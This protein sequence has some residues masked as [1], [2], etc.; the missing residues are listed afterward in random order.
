[1]AEDDCN[2]GQPQQHDEGHER[3]QAI[4][5]IVNTRKNPVKKAPNKSNLKNI[6]RSNQLLQALDLPTVMNVN[7]R[8]I[9]NKV[10]EFHNL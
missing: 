10:K 4:P 2:D 7:P 1:M 5:V 3:N 6:K 8:S 9:Y